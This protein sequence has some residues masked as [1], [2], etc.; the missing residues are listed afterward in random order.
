[1]SGRRSLGWLAAGVLLS[2]CGTATQTTQTPK[3]TPKSSASPTAQVVGSQRTVLSQLGLNIH[4]DMSSTAPVVATAAR[5]VTLSVLDYRP[6]GGGWYK[7]Q[8]QNTTGWIVAD[9]A[10]TASGVFTSYASTER[11]F[12]A[13]IPN[14]WTFAEEAAAVV[15]RPQQGD[16]NIVVRSGANSAALGPQSPN[17]YIAQSATEQVVCGYTGLLSSYRQGASTGSPTTGASPSASSA[18][19]HLSNYAVI[20][21]TFDAAHTMEIAYNYSSDDQLAIFQDFYNSI[22]FP[23]PQCQA[24]APAAPAAPAPT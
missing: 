17:G 20:R 7:V 9:P 23:F 13:L 21:L 24:P 14:T 11:G 5:G 1:M 2:A 8:G 19:R 22:S 12:S 15:L 4:S 10:L 6:D 3:G 16:Q 18:A